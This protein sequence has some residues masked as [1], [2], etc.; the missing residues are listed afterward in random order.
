M[1][2]FIMLDKNHRIYRKNSE[3]CLKMCNLIKLSNK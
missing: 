2:S 3:L 1:G